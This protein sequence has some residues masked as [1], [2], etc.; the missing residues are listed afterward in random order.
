MVRGPQIGMGRSSDPNA[1]VYDA[2]DLLADNRGHQSSSAPPSPARSSY[3]TRSTPDDVSRYTIDSQDDDDDV[4]TGSEGDDDVSSDDGSTDSDDDDNDDDGDSGSDSDDDSDSG[5]EED[6]EK[7]NDYDVNSTAITEVISNSNGYRSTPN[8]SRAAPRAAIGGGSYEAGTGAG[9]TTTSPPAPPASSFRNLHKHFPSYLLD[10]KGKGKGKGKH[11]PLSTTEEEGEYD[12]ESNNN[13]GNNNN[14]KQRKVFIKEP[15][16]NVRDPAQFPLEQYTDGQYGQDFSYASYSYATSDPSNIE[17]DPKPLRRMDADDINLNQRLQ[18]EEKKRRI[19][20]YGVLTA[21]FISFIIAMA[22]IVAHVKRQHVKM[23]PLT[24]DL[25]KL[26]DI[27][28]ISKLDGNKQCEE[29]CE[30]AKCCMAPGSLSCFRGQEEVCSLVSNT[31]LQN[32]CNTTV[33]DCD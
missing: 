22:S 3:S 32:C 4:S 21:I 26:C 1:S 8:R 30:E 15:I 33:I 17:Y 13:I 29:A 27:A 6:S 19:I 24:L 10:G 31:I 23:P 2:V 5:S 9:S 28:N 18:L 20:F 14:N 7:A 25:E 11:V 12:E 16:N